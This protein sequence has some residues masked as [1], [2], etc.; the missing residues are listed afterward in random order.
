MQRND[1]GQALCLGTKE[2]HSLVSRSE[3]YRKNIMKREGS[4]QFGR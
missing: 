4:T 3:E 1:I 2:V